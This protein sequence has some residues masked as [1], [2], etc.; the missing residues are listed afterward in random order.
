MDTEDLNVV[1]T[2]SSEKPGNEADKAQF[3]E[4]N[5]D[6]GQ[7]W[8]A[9]DSDTNPF[10]EFKFPELV[11][12]K[13]VMTRAFATDGTDVNYRL[14]YVPVSQTDFVPLGELVELD[15]SGEPVYVS[16]L[17]HLTSGKNGFNEN[18]LDESVLTKVIRLHPSAGVGIKVKYQG[19]LEN[20]KTTVPVLVETTKQ[21]LVTTTTP[22]EVE[23]TPIS[24]KTTRK[25]E[26][27]TTEVKTELPTTGPSEDTTTGPEISTGV[28]KTTK[29]VETTTEGRI[30]SLSTAGATTTA[31]PITEIS[32]TTEI[33]IQYCDEAMGLEIGTSNEL[34]PKLT[35]SSN[36]DEVRKFDI[37]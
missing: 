1:V 5:G 29:L 2:S 15:E 27:V 23:T 18:I 9:V 37:I 13:S 21:V 19:C 11:D 32:V 30:T 24:T 22:I 33:P 4:V 16:K 35:A 3:I 34:N 25:T 26:T 20:E 10:I 17:F 12:I 6:N 14:S 7:F 36:A 31:P 28:V 8:Q